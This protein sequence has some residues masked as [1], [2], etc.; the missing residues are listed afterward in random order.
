MPIPPQWK[1]QHIPVAAQLA[2]YATGS[3]LETLWLQRKPKQEAQTAALS[4]LAAERWDKCD[5][6]FLSLILD[7]PMNRKEIQERLSVGRTNTNVRVLRLIDKGYVI[8]GEAPG[9]R[10]KNKPLIITQSG[11]DFLDRQ[12]DTE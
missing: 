8:E 1:G 7:S 2:G 4:K 11:R 9:H 5:A 10:S 6:E 3:T 12:S